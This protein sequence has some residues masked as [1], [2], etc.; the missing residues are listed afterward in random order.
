MNVASGVQEDTAP[1]EA[2]R[3]NSRIYALWACLVYLAAPVTYVGVVQAALCDKLGA[4]PTVANLP[5]SLYLLGFAAPLVVAWAVPQRYERMAAAAANGLSCVMLTLVAAVLWL[6]AGNSLR[7]AAIIGQG[8]TM[9]V[10]ASTAQV[11]MLQCLCRGT[12][13]AGRARGFRW[14]FGAGPIAAVAGSLGAQYVLEGGIPAL[15]YP[16]DFALLYSFGAVCLAVAAAGAL[17]FKLPPA[18]EPPRLPMLKHV[19][20]SVRSFAADR[21]LRRLWM[22]YVLWF[23]A[24]YAA[25]NFSLYTRELLGRDPKELSGLIMALRFASK[26]AAGFLLA[27]LI[28]RRGARAP[29][30]AAVLLTVA[31]AAWA[32]MVPGYLFLLAFALLGAGELGGA[33]FPNYVAGVSLLAAGARNQAVLALATPAASFGPALHGLL[34]VRYGFGASFVFA[35]VAALG[36]L[37]LVCTLPRGAGSK[38]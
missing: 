24:V 38:P 12:N 18:E 37:M 30:V 14:A 21:P 6:P 20:A 31:A 13:E 26:S 3:V 29:V 19:A 2:D 15:A 1:P 35:A 8:C 36:A 9:G 27:S 32:G 23:T 16:R 34:T 11:F 7:I 5:A 28:L 4:S 10:T 17:R 25:P 33:Y 22:A